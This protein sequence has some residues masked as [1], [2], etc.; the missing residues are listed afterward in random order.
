LALPFINYLD[1]QTLSVAAP[2]L[3]EEFLM[4]NEDY[5]FVLSS[6]M[7]AYADN[8]LISAQIVWAAPAW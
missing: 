1:R 3:R 5:G 4:S 7:L 2:A 8:V 6:F